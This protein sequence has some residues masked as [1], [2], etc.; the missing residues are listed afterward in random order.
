MSSLTLSSEL[1]FLSPQMCDLVATSLTEIASIHELLY[2]YVDVVAGDATDRVHALILD[3]HPV[4]RTPVASALANP[5]FVLRLANPDRMELAGVSLR[6]TSGGGGGGGGVGS[7]KRGSRNEA[8]RKARAAVLLL[9]DASFLLSQRLPLT[10]AWLF[11]S[12]RPMVALS[13]CLCQSTVTHYFSLHTPSVPVDARGLGQRSAG[14]GGYAGPVP[15]GDCKG[16]LCRS[17]VH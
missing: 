11:E 3:T 10:G 12:G 4:T 17:A 2:T 14:G 15:R 13:F 8:D 16:S 5:L 1:P 6:Q 7:S 9:E